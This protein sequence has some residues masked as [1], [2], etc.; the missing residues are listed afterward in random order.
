M[1]FLPAFRLVGS[2]A[3]A[4]TSDMTLDEVETSTAFHLEF[5]DMDGSSFS[6]GLTIAFEGKST[7]SQ[8]SYSIVFGIWS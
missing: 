5:E 3:E 7:H 2:R 1:S 8:P 6:Y 4:D